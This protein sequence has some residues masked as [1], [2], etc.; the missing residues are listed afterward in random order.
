MQKMTTTVWI[1]EIQEWDRKKKMGCCIDAAKEWIRPCRWTFAPQ[2]TRGVRMGY[3]GM[4]VACHCCGRCRSAC[5]SHPVLLRSRRRLPID[6]LQR[7]TSYYRWR[8]GNSPLVW[9]WHSVVNAGWHKVTIYPDHLFFL[10]FLSTHSS[11]KL[12]SMQV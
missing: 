8:F 9:T 10:M 7:N 2:Q 3:V 11:T 5:W 4:W 1:C 6:E 12:D